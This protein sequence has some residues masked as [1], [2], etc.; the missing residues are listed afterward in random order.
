[1]VIELNRQGRI[2]EKLQ[3]IVKH[4]EFPQFSKRL[5]LSMFDL[6]KR[7]R[8]H[9]RFIRTGTLGLCVF[10]IKREVANL[11]KTPLLRKS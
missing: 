3:K 1:M 11:F 7:K 5:K 10:F 4:D 9:L 2:I 8:V 6:F